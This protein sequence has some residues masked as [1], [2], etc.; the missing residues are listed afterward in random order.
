MTQ[1]VTMTVTS[2]SRTG[3]SS[4]RNEG[5]RLEQCEKSLYMFYKKLYKR[6]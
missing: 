6:S 3:S 4:N 2:M 1:N 5:E